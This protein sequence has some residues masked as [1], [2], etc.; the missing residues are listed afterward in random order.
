M[1][2]T[3]LPHSIDTLQINDLVN[4]NPVDITDDIVNSTFYSDVIISFTSAHF[5]GSFR[6][7]YLP[8]M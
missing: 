8:G 2:K 3:N 6:I 4:S 1:M 5:K 7:Q